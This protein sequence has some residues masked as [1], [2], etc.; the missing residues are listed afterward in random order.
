MSCYDAWR[1]FHEVCF[2]ILLYLRGFKSRFNCFRATAVQTWS[3]WDFHLTPVLSGTNVV[4][5]MFK[6]QSAIIKLSGQ[7]GCPAV[8]RPGCYIVSFGKTQ[9][10]Q[11][12]SRYDS[13]YG[14]KKKKKNLY[15][16]YKMVLPSYIEMTF[17]QVCAVLSP[18]STYHADFICTSVEWIHWHSVCICQMWWDFILGNAIRWK[19]TTPDRKC[20]E[21]SWM[22]ELMTDVVW[23]ML[24]VYSFNQWIKH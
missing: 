14:E 1:T 5:L 20:K 6:G 23:F 8:L 21:T 11:Q 22:F 12:M 24:N 9:F 3:L 13:I 10:M 4:H 2:K 17:W 19:K 16:F 15:V 7:R 18:V